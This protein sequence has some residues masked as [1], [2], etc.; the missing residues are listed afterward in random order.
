MTP[1]TAF[2]GVLAQNMMEYGGLAGSLAGIISNV[3]DTVSNVVH[4][5]STTTWAVIAAAA[6][7]LWFFLRR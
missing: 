4:Q 7:G 1:P 5:T 6:I 3:F 2:S